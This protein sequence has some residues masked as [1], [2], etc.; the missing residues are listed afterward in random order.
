MEFNV[1]TTDLVEE[2]LVL[3]VPLVD[4]RGL[5]W[6]KVSAICPILTILDIYVV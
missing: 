4:D 3:D 2:H 5:L 6:K 1:T